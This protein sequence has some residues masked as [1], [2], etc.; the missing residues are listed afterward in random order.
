MSG[1]HPVAETA[2]EERAFV[3]TTLTKAR[4]AAHLDHR[5]SALYRDIE[6]HLDL[7]RLLPHAP[8]RQE[9]QY[10]A[11]DAQIQDDCSEAGHDIGD[12]KP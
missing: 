5:W 2:A 7:S 12:L 6:S 10:F 8:D 11:A 1:R 9:R 3:Q 4:T